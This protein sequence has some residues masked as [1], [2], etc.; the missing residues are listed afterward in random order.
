MELYNVLSHTHNVTRWGDSAGSMSVALQMITNGGNTEGL[1]RG[2]IM[3]S[4]FMTSIVGVANDV[5]EQQ[6]YDFIV[7]GVGCTNA[8]DTLECLRQAPLASIMAA[9]TATPGLYSTQVRILEIGI[10][11]QR[12]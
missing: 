1:F 7:G 10:E 8:T 2:A 6:V 12:C 4:G 11:T 9:V 3:E 5:H